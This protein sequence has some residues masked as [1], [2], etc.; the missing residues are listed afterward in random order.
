MAGQ[1]SDGAY[2]TRGPTSTVY[3]T[4]SADPASLSKR[5]RLE[6]YGRDGSACTVTVPVTTTVGE[7]ATVSVTST[8]QK[9]TS[10]TMATVTETKSNGKAYAIATATAT[11]SGVCG[12]TVNATAPTS[13]VTVDARCA[14]SALTSAYNGYGLEYADHVVGGGARYTTP[15]DDASQC[16][17]QC[18]DADQCAASVWDIRTNQCILEFP[19]SFSSGEL[20]C[21]EG[22]LVFYGAGPLHPKAPGSGLYVQALC[23]DVHFASA[24]P[25]DGS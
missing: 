16:C 9:Y 14:P 19:V 17:Q 13:T 24:P 22:A 3:T 4:A 5:S 23:G 20:S 2:S 25:D 15:T 6:L 11:T 12:P 7:T 10:F 1:S 18:A 21:G 8:Y